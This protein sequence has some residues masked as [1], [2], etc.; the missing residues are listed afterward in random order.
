[1]LNTNY[2]GASQF[3]ATQYP[4][5]YAQPYGQPYY[6]AAPQ[7]LSAISYASEEEVR[8]YFLSPNSQVF[9]LDKEKPFFYIKTADNLGRS[10]L[11]KYKFEE[12][13]ENAPVEAPQPE[14]ITKGDIEALT[15]EL[16]MLKLRYKMLEEKVWKPTLG[17][18]NEQSKPA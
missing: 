9:A 15:K 14:Y 2:F 1:M 16:D 18:K 3:G 13:A 5:G 10:T 17:G 11:T 4:Q 6:Q 12:L 8:G 7:K